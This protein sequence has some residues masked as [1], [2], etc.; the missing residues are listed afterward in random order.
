MRKLI[1]IVYY[2]HRS[3]AGKK[4]LNLEFDI[5]PSLPEDI[6]TDRTRLNQILTNL[7]S[8]AIKFTPSGTI[9]PIVVLSAEAF[10]DK[11]EELLSIG[12]DDYLTKPIEMDKLIP[13]LKKVSNCHSYNDSE[14]LHLTLF[15]FQHTT[16]KLISLHGLEQGLK[17]AF[18]KSFI[19]LTLNEFEKYRAN[20][21]FGKNL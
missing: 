4:S 16:A 9:R 18:P 15:F 14:L 13:I 12:A 20:H 8:N 17:I 7:I 2:M 6:R 1:D 5:E 3:E 21:G 19:S 11:Q 10:T